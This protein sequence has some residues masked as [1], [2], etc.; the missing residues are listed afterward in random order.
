MP[1]A[2]QD[3][4]VKQ[5]PEDDLI[6]LTDDGDAGAVDPVK[7]DDALTDASSEIDGYVGSRH[8]LPLATVPPIIGKQCVDIAIYNLYARRGGPPEHIEKRYQNAVRFLEKVAKGDITMGAE[9][10]A[11]TGSADTAE[12]LPSDRV[13]TRDTLAGY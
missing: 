11:G 1:Y 8:A 3:D 5:I 10:P 2:T 7:V 6:M 4:L 13:F 9:D 12:A